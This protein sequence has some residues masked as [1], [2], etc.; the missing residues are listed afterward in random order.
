MV[1]VYLNIPHFEAND[2]HLPLPKSS[3]F[4]PISGWMHIRAAKQFKR[5]YPKKNSHMMSHRCYMGVPIY[6]RLV[7]M[8]KDKVVY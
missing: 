5:L 4:T 2:C 3:V 7:I 8:D 1:R 6:H